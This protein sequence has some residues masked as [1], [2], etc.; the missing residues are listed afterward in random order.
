[1]TTSLRVVAA[2][3]LAALACAM[4]AP[5]SLGAAEERFV[6]ASPGP[7]WTRH[8]IDDTCTGA[9]GVK[10]GD[11][12]G[13]GLPDIV[14]S[15]E[16]GG[17]VRLYLNPGYAK[18]RQAWPRVTV[19]N[20]RD[21]EDA[22]LADLDGDGRLDVVSC[23]E[24]KTRTVFWHRFVGTAGDW[25]KAERWSTVAFPA[26]V[27][28]QSWMQAAAMD[29]DG[30]HGPDLILASK[31][32]G[33]AVGWLQAP[34]S[35]GNLA[36]WQYHRLRE[37]GWVMSLVPQ[38]MD[39]DGDLDVVFSDRK[40]A[41]T[42]V[43]WLENPG[44]QANRGHAAWNEHAIGAV[45]RQVMFADLADVN[46]DGL[47]DV[48]VAVK[49]VEVVLCLQRPGHTWQEITL[50]LNPAGLGDAKAAKAADIN[51]DGRMDLVFTCENAKRSLEGIVWLEQP[52]SGPWKQ[53]P[54]GGPQGVKYDLVQTL[55][56]DGDGDLDVLT[57]EERDQLGVV[58]YENPHRGAR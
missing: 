52:G 29:V 56:L 35:P 53:H 17:E 14:T 32:A 47:L 5:G 20:V 57:C 36:A 1:M 37:A 49:P 24:G 58:W 50:R 4:R 23:T 54:L 27:K 43:F 41:H 21:V 13:D 40:G 16:E 19:G 33:A 39:G 51:G 31:G 55:D 48:A 45:G 6:V 25:T 28:S 30:Q 22:I 26:T 44:A 42:G 8:A 10:L 2:L 34:R 15:W 9:D 11:I 3:T 7:V 18:A 38:D 12:N 46:G